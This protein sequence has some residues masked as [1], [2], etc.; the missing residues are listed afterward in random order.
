[1]RTESSGIENENND[2]KISMTMTDN[3]KILKKIF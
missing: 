3:I 1:M 2:P